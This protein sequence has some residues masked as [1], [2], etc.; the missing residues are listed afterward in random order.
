[1]YAKNVCESYNYCYIDI[2][3]ID[4]NILKYNHGE[5]SMKVSFFIYA[6]LESLIGKIYTC[7]NNLKKSSTSK[8]NQQTVCFYSLLTYFHLKQQK[9]S[10]IIIQIKIA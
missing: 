3:K 9:T 1:M 4:N 10:M 8:I 2:P 6:D 7:H 5:K